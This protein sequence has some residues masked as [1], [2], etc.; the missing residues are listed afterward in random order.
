VP[1]PIAPQ[2]RLPRIALAAARLIALAAAIG[3]VGCSTAHYGTPRPPA[4][5]VESHASGHG[6]EPGSLA[7]LD[8]D[9]IRY[10]QAS[11]SVTGDAEDGSAY[12]VQDNIQWLREHPGEDLPWGGPIRVFR[13][14]AFMDR[15]GP[16]ARDS[17][18]GDPVNLENGKIYTLDHR[19]LVAYREAGRNTIAVE[20]ANVRLVRDQ[21][22]KFTTANGGRSI[23]AGP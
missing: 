11:Y 13:K 2:G 18:V 21:R 23:E 22:W 7:R 4:G 19:R 14:Q 1:V 16:L 5:G 6:E 3:L 17:F 8:V 15:W 20:W 12:S 9:K 10:S